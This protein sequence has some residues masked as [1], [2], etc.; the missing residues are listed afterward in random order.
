MQPRDKIP[1]LKVALSSLIKFPKEIKRRLKRL[2][3]PAL[4]VEMVTLSNIQ[5]VLT[6]HRKEKVILL[7]QVNTSPSL[8]FNLTLRCLTSVIKQKPSRVS[9]VSFP[10]VRNSTKER[11]ALEVFKET[12]HPVECC[13]G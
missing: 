7:K 2:M 5:L 9:R 13:Q 3:E 4:P 1:L 12:I 8:T 11:V 6:N 10:M